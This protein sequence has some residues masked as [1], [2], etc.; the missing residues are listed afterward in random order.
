MM[1]IITLMCHSNGQFSVTKNLG[2]FHE[3]R[4][5]TT[6]AAADA[7]AMQLQ[8]EAGGPDN[9]KI[10]VHNLPTAD[11]SAMITEPIGPSSTV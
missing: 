1:V 5:F 8:A 6:R 11:R 7:H 4:V 9:A 2:G 10:I 3:S